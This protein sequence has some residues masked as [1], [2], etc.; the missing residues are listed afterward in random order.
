MQFS[1]SLLY[2]RRLNK[3]MSRAD[4]AHAVRRS[5]QGQIKATERGVRG[6]EKNEYA[7]RGEVIPALA[8]A[9]GCEMADLYEVNGKNAIEDDEESRTVAL[10][11]HK[12]MLAA[13]ALALEP[14]LPQRAAVEA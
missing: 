13:L 4:L 2:Q 10:V 5:S 14:F 11:D 9:L 3:N 7:P 8:S 12:E 1:G 6:W